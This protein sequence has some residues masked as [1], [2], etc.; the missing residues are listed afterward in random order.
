VIQEWVVADYPELRLLRVGLRQALDTQALI[1][2]KELDDV[3]ERMAIVATELATN[4]L[5]H[6]RSD[7][8]VR[9]SRTKKTFVLDVSDDLP[10]VPPQMAEDRPPAV[11]GRGLHITQELATDIGWYRANGRKHLW[12][13]FNIPRRSR[14]F[15][16][17]RI[18]VFNLKTLIRLLRRIG[19]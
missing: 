17:P 19:S 9:L 1:P 10:T 11:G 2:G 15:Q 18:P 13:Q 16:A 8:V 6:A 5:T 3:V 14:R 12:A 7:A 4:A